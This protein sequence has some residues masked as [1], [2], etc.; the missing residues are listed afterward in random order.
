[1]YV[2]VC[3][4]RYVCMQSYVCVYAYTCMHEA[5]QRGTNPSK[6]LGQ[7]AA[8]SKPHTINQPMDKK[9]QDTNRPPQAVEFRDHTAAKTFELAIQAIAYHECQAHR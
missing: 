3:M 6:F 1:M 9:K 7:L 8:H 5:T 4:Q 2:P